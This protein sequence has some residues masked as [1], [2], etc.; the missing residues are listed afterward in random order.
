MP[1]DTDSLANKSAIAV[2]FWFE[3]FFIDE[4]C[5]VQVWSVTG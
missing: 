5:A 3:F 4:S 2:T 1:F